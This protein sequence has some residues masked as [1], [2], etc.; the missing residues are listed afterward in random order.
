MSMNTHVHDDNSDIN[1]FWKYIEIENHDNILTQIQSTMVPELLEG[2]RRGLFH[3]DVDKFKKD[4]PLFMDWVINNSLEIGSI[5][6][7]KTLAHSAQDIHR[8]YTQSG[9][10]NT[11]ALNLNLYNCAETYTKMFKLKDG[12][13][14]PP[15][16]YG[17]NGKPF[18][19]YDKKNC[20]EVTSYMLCKPVILNIAQLHQVINN[21]AKTR[22]S[23]SFRFKNLLNLDRF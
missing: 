13:G 21:T 11:Y 12:M 18:F 23:V 3:Y 15:I 1:F 16:S 20:I 2:P 17:P 5:A 8:D 10:G 14:L 7:I 9:P 4:C 19:S 22:M 6:I